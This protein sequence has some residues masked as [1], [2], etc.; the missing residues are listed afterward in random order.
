[1][2][3]ASLGAPGNKPL[4]SGRR[5]HSTAGISDCT[6]RPMRGAQAH[7]R[8]LR[9][10]CPIS[11]MAWLSSISAARRKDNLL[12][13]L[14]VLFVEMFEPL[15]DQEKPLFVVL[16]LLSQTQSR[17]YL[18]SIG[19]RVQIVRHRDGRSQAARSALPKPPAVDS[20][21]S[22]G[23]KDSS[24]SSVWRSPPW[25]KIVER[26]LYG[27]SLLIRHGA[28]RPLV[29]PPRTGFEGSARSCGGNL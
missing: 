8:L 21:R 13:Y 10:S 1:M 24:S 2:T 4:L 9:N 28:S 7:S 16:C 20:A 19:R 17:Q 25:T 22:L 27:R 23:N 14:D 15:C 3:K 26:R 18:E 5:N 6:E 12:L 29:P 11:A